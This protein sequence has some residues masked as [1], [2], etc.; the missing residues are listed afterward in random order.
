MKQLLAKVELVKVIKIG[1]PYPD[2]DA[3]TQFIRVPCEVEAR[4]DGKIVTKR[5]DLAVRPIHGQS[6]R[7]AV[8]GGL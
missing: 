6:D 4:E 8:G 7:W 5:L 1:E 3:R 2:E